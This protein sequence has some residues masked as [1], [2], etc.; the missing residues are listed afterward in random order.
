MCGADAVKLQTYTADTIKIKSDMPDFRIQAGPWRNYNL[1]DLYKEAQ[2]PFEWHTD[3]FEHAK[4]I[5]ITVFSSPFDETAVDLL[6]DLGTPAYKIASFEAVDIPLI[7]YVASTHKPLLISTGMAS[8]LEIQE[9][10][11][12][13]YET[14]CKELLLLHLS[15]IHI[16]EPTRPLYRS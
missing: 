8:E 10:I 2:T 6:E 5:G 7:R 12:T 9:A 11:E 13:A 16:S 3:I 4:K 1:Y 15:L 14:G